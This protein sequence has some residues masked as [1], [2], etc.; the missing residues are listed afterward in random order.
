MD[1]TPDYKNGFEDG[2][3]AGR[4]DAVTHAHWVRGVIYLD[5]EYVGK[6]CKCSDCLATYASIDYPHCPNC[7]AI[8]D[9]PETEELVLRGRV[10]DDG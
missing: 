10:K 3:K 9:E 1:K 5:G 4:E 7:G 8:M 6:V 2:Y